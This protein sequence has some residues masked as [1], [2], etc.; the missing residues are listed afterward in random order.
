MFFRLAPLAIVFALLTALPAAALPAAEGA[1]AAVVQ[2]DLEFLGEATVEA[3]ETDGVLRL[4]D[5]S[6]AVLAGLELPR[7]PLQIDPASPWPVA[8]QAHDVL[9]ELVMGRRLRLYRGGRTADR[10]GRRLV[11]AF[12]ADGVWLQ[13]DLLSRGWARVASTPDARLAVRPMLA[14]EAGARRAS[15]GL[16]A[17]PAYGV[18]RPD[19]VDLL[20][21]STQVVEGRV[22]AADRW[23]SGLYLS[24]GEWRK[25]RLT[26]HLPPAVVTLA[27]ADTDLAAAA[28]DPHGLIG[29]RLRVRGWIGKERGPRLEVSHPEQIELIE[30]SARS[31]R[32]YRGRS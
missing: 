17:L 16:W 12:T 20:V 29:R 15:L 6:R 32:T 13:G 24:L 28:A 25:R 4:D 5:Q 18:R 2:A 3:V 31:R 21:D 27:L 30:E 23:K 1:A 7:R 9:A 11:Q 19:E 22:I 10:Y 14:A 8:E 26:V